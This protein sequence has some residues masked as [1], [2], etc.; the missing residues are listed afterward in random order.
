[1]R[2]PFAFLNDAIQTDGVHGFEQYAVGAI[3]TR[4]SRSLRAGRKRPRCPTSLN[5]DSYFPSIERSFGPDTTFTAKYLNVHRY[6]LPRLRNSNGILP[7]VYQ[8][9]QSSSSKYQG[10]SIALNHRLTHEFSYLV[11]YM[12]SR[13]YDEASDFNQQPL[14][15]NNTRL[16]WSRS[17]QY[18][19]HRVAAGGVFELPFSEMLGAPVW[20]RRFSHEFELGPGVSYGSARPINTLETTDVY[21]TGAYPIS[22]RPVG[23]AR[24]TGNDSGLFSFDARIGKGFIVP[25][26]H[27]V[28]TVGLNAFNLTNHKNPL[29]VSP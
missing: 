7:P 26:D 13:V 15:P 10:V 23:F 21:R 25:K 27:G 18:Q 28:I 12:E 2:Y 11:S 24:N 6:H 17:D 9:E 8:L 20:L 3:A 5:L 14:D 1:M 29:R 22:A 4:P 16:D 19:A